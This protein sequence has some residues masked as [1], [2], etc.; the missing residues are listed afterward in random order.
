MGFAITRGSGRQL[1]A[2]D[3]CDIPSALDPADGRDR[4]RGLEILPD[5]HNRPRLDDLGKYSQ[6][7]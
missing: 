3:C 7:W 6:W 4:L 2:Q 5:G 1:R